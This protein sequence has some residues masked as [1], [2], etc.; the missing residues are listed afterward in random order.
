MIPDPPDVSPPAS[1]QVAPLRQLYGE[2]RAAL[3][4]PDVRGA[5]RIVRRAGEAG[6]RAG[7]LYAEVIRPALAELQHPQRDARVR[8]AAGIGDSILAD[9]VRTLPP[10]GT[11]G[12]GRSGVLSC[13]ELGIEAV[14][15]T[16]AIDF[17]EADGWSVE[18]QRTPS[19]ELS[20]P[21]DAEVE[22]AVAVTSGP[23]DALRLASVCAELRR[24]PDPPVILL[25]DFSGRSRNLGAAAALGAD[26][27]VNDPGELVTAA[28]ERSPAAG[29]RRWGVRLARSG[30]TLRL[31]PTGRLDQTSVGRLADVALSRLGTFSNL[32]LDVSDVVAT[33][34]AGILALA[35]WP[36]LLAPEEVELRLVCA[37]AGP[38]ARSLAG[39]GSRWRFGDEVT[40]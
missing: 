15:G 25:C 35:E 30:Q 38:A 17:L 37:G 12:A 18:R 13:R 26:A 5:R 6:H 29:L 4:A 9:L 33:E 34:P 7:A 10:A 23:R 31:T 39:L 19:G 8:L 27:V 2:F 40:A 36:S 3:M 32:V 11:R 16:V 22:L 21:S 24:L 28:A 1:E 20:L 14:D